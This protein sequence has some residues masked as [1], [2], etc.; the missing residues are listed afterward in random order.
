MKTFFHILCAILF[1]GFLIVVGNRCYHT[2]S[3]SETESETED[4]TIEIRIMCEQ[5]LWLDTEGLDTSDSLLRDLVDMCNA[6]TAIRSI[7]TDFDLYMRMNDY[8]SETRDA[9]LSLDL[10]VVKDSVTRSHLEEYR[11][12]MIGLYGVRANEVDQDVI[13]PYLYRYEADEYIADRYSLTHYYNI[14]IDELTEKLLTDY[15]TCESVP[16][17]DSLQA[18][19][20][21]LSIEQELH[22]R[23]LNSKSFDE[24]CIYAIELAYANVAGHYVDGP[25]L[26]YMHRLLTCGQYSMYLYSI[27]LRW[28]CIY[29]VNYGGSSK[30]SYI[31][32]WFYN[33]VRNQ[34]LC[35]VLKH[36]ATHPD[37][38]M[39][40]N[41][42]IQLASASNIY[43]LG[44]FE[45]G[46]QNALEYYELF[47]EKQN[48]EDRGE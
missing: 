29:Q 40:F 46:N 20:G 19:R 1:S 9:I 48:T 12:K 39:A 24:Q 21:D 25:Y 18:K 27:W 37:D 7:F 28:R 38:M 45:Y 22:T 17:W 13:N 35:T 14:D 34:C 47:L 31:P 23:Y 43:R 41:Q 4:H 10:S 16:D 42:L 32:N 5:E 15:W 8:E 11:H 44:T 3:K 6:A 2:M 36:I 30:D 33:Q 26:R